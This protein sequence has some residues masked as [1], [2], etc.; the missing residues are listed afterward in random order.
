MA[1]ILLLAGAA[2]AGAD[3]PGP[4]KYRSEV[5]SVVPATSAVRLRFIGGD[6][7]VELTVR[8]GHTAEVTGYRGE[9]YVRV[10]ADGVVRENRA[11]PTW[12]LSQSR[13][14]SGSATGSAVPQW[15]VVARDGV[16]AWHDHRTHWMNPEPPPGAKPGDQVLEAVVPL[17]VDRTA[18]KVT[19]ASYLLA[20]PGRAT[21]LGLLGLAVA[22]AVAVGWT[23]RRGIQGVGTVVMVTAAL[24]IALGTVAFLSVPRLT[25]PPLWDWALP[26]AAVVALV[27]AVV[28]SARRR[29]GHF[30]VPALV[31]LAG[32]ELAVWA[33]L[34]RGVVSAALLPTR[35]P[36]WMDR[37]A[38][39]AA[40]GAGVAT[41]VVAVAHMARESARP[42]RAD[43]QSRTG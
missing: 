29:L 18:V 33:W 25:G 1:A 14:G 6:S 24:A 36:A 7:F 19:V 23:S 10:A 30:A 8:R 38:V 22:V 9:P 28:P 2:R 43:S 27:V 17:R 5:V 40:A 15:R 3:P 12:A 35:A 11:S 13:Y 42:N 32:A 16:F 21:S 4:T 20:G 31:G 37:V 34:R 39:A 41:V 26:L